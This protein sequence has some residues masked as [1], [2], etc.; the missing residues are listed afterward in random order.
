MHQSWSSFALQG[1]KEDE[2]YLFHFKGWRRFYALG[3]KGQVVSMYRPLKQDMVIDEV[4]YFS[5]I[6]KPNSLSNFHLS[7]KGDF[8]GLMQDATKWVL[9]WRALKSQKSG[10]FLIWLSDCIA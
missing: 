7:M 4:V 8:M 10:M 6:D 3:D 9:F 1:F 5:D 2:R